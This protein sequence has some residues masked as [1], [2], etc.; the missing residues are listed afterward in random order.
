M[1]ERNNEKKREIKVFEGKNQLE[2]RKEN[3]GARPHGRGSIWMVSNGWVEIQHL[4]FMA[5]PRE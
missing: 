3:N 1:R 5:E 2:E 4:R